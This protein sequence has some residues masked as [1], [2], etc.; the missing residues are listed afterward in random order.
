MHATDKRRSCR[1]PRLMFEQAFGWRHPGQ[2]VFPTTPCQDTDRPSEVG[3]VEAP[4]VDERVAALEQRVERLERES[5]QLR[6]VLG[7]A[8]GLL[9]D[10]DLSREVPTTA[11]S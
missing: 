3:T 4:T 2:P 9:S 6:R 7:A 11:S 8:G 5:V 1:T 10:P